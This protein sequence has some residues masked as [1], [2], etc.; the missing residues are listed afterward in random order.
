MGICGACADRAV[1][2]RSCPTCAVRLCHGCEELHQHEAER[3]TDADAAGQEVERLRAW[4]RY[5]GANAR[6]LGYDCAGWALDSTDWPPDR[7][8]STVLRERRKAAGA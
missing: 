2:I 1:R 8:A 7:P 4:L 5:I 3:D 6:G